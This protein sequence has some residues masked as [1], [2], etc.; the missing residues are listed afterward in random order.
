[1]FNHLYANFSNPLKPKVIYSSDQARLI[2]KKRIPRIIFDFIDGATGTESSPKRNFT[3]FERINL[4]PRVLKNVSIRNLNTSLLG[5]N[6]SLPF[7]FSPMGMSGISWPNADSFLANTAIEKNIP[8][9]VSTA[10]SISLENMRNKAGEHSWF[11]LYSASTFDETLPLIE[12]ARAAGYTKLVL[13][14]DVPQVSKRIRDLQNGFA[15]PF[16][17]GPIQFIDFAC[18]PR[19]SIPMLLHL[20]LIHI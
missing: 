9:V 19:W 15:M 7:G 6:F 10:A 8:V 13:T 17:I 3:A 5:E 4:Q 16:K 14:V 20:S 1:M 11:Q 2:A 18:H 12:R